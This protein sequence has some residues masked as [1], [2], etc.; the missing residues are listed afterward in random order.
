MRTY[1][2]QNNVDAVVAFVDGRRLAPC[3]ELRM[4]KPVR[5]SAFA[6]DFLAKE[7]AEGFRCNNWSLGISERHRA[8]V[9]LLVEARVLHDPLEQSRA[10]ASIANPIAVVGSER[11]LVAAVVDAVGRSAISPITTV[12]AVVSAASG[13][14]T[15]IE[16]AR[17]WE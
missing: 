1:C 2:R 8:V 12:Q 6:R 3:S 5:K 14:S 9:L 7:R 10:F 4:G 11:G 15:V 16:I 17:G 13:K